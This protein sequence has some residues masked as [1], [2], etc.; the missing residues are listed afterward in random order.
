MG[1]KKTIAAI[2]FLLLCLGTAQGGSPVWK[3]T[4]GGDSEHTLFMGGTIHILGK[5]DYPL[6]QAFDM[7]YDQSQILVF[8]TDIA[9][10]QDP[11]FSQRLMSRMVYS[12]NRTLKQLISPST[13]RNL[14]QFAG[15]RG[16]SVNQMNR[17]KPGLVMIFLTLTEIE[18]LGVAGI[19]V[20]EFYFEKGI[21][22]HKTMDFLEAPEEQVD[23]L[24]T[25]GQGNEDEMI[26]YILKDL[27]ELPSL[28]PVIKK[29]WRT[30]DIEEL[31]NTTLVPLKK[32]YP[33]LYHSIMV[34]RNL[35]WMP[36]IQKMLT[37]QEVEFILVGAGHLAG[38]QGLLAL[39]RA[40]GYTAVNQ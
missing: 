38:D 5:S 14:N 18:R 4:N 17:F 12:D 25:I 15:V 13:L 19:G 23:F 33:D 36:K 34:K 2:V 8:E 32:E 6:P 10:T 29:T 21:K 27:G 28:L 22:D 35:N 37:T 16:I 39:L 9:K 31:F 7:A 20:D 30:G 11:E 24:E 40:K 1:F 26:A 3:I